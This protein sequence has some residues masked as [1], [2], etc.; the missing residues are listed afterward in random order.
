[1][2]TN[3]MLNVQT[4][5]NLL[6]RKKKKKAGESIW[7]RPQTIHAIPPTVDKRNDKI[8]LSFTPIFSKRRPERM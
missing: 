3:S 8:R 1:M 4:I 2:A 5:P 7:S 6:I